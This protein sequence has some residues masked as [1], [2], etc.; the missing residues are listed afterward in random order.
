MDENDIEL[1][2][3]KDKI[4]G[5]C[6]TS[7]TRTAPRAAAST[8]SGVGMSPSNQA[9]ALEM[10]G[11]PAQ[12]R[13]DGP[14][15]YAE[16]W[17]FDSRFQQH[18]GGEI[19]CEAQAF[20][21][22]EAE[23]AL[24]VVWLNHAFT[25][26]KSADIWFQIHTKTGAGLCSMVVLPDNAASVRWRAKVRR[27]PGTER[28]AD[29]EDVLEL[30]STEGWVGYN[31]AG[32]VKQCSTGSRVLDI[33]SSDSDKWEGGSYIGVLWRKNGSGSFKHN[34]K[35]L[36]TGFLHETGP[37][38]LALILRGDISLRIAPESAVEHLRQEQV[39][40]QQ[41]LWEQGGNS[42]PLI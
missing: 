15:Q 7:S 24:S 8:A 2:A 20:A 38:R 13:P 4:V 30:A 22:P 25:S 28:D 29:D 21:N 16:S 41:I 39:D 6:P 27:L 40:W 3:I 37:C 23:D 42:T 35:P 10:P 11:K 5:L 36:V 32:Q 12:S 9:V 18:V 1:D 31:S 34:G 26:T 17:E 33:Y 19:M 14:V